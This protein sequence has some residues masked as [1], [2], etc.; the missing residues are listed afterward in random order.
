M[1]KFT[2]DSAFTIA[3]ETKEFET[4]KYFIPQYARHRPACQA[5]L[6][7]RYYEPQTHRLIRFLLKSYPGNVVHAGTFFGDMLPSFSRS[8]GSA[9]RVYAFEPL[10][11]NYILARLSVDANKLGNVALFNS[12]L[13]DKVAPCLM[14]RVRDNEHSG[15]A[16]HVSST[17][18]V[19][20]TVVTIDSL[21]LDQLSVLQLDVEGEELSALKGAVRTINAARPVILVEDNKRNC[22]P[23]MTDLNYLPVAR[24]PGLQIWN[25]GEKPGVTAAITAFLSPAPECLGPPISAK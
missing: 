4:A 15:G 6:N 19:S 18:D 16:S 5:F 8:C 9:G 14:G 22:G 17:G 1:D 3:F 10:L 12:A 25:A 2:T 24:I 7:N 23:L 11:E 13:G 21:G 20:S